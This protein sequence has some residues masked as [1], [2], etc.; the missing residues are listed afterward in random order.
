M[1]FWTPVRLRSGPPFFDMSKYNKEFEYTVVSFNV[2][3][4]NCKRPSKLNQSLYRDSKSKT[5]H[6]INGKGCVARL[7][8][9][10]K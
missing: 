5:H 8:S 9:N 2:D 4:S 1:Y 10:K 6:T 7:F 3:S